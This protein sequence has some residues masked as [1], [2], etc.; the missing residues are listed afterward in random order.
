MKILIWLFTFSFFTASCISDISDPALEEALKNG[1]VSR[2][3]DDGAT[4]FSGTPWA[5]KASMLTA[6]RFSTCSV[7]D[8]KIY[9]FGGKDDS[10]NN[11][12]S[13]EVYDPIS[14]S[15]SYKSSMDTD[16]NSAA[17]V[18]V[19][20]RILIFGGQVYGSP[21]Y[22]MDVVAEYNPTSDTWVNKSQVMPAAI[23]E[24]KAEVVNNLVYLFGGT[25]ASGS[26]LSSVYE[27]DP[28]GDTYTTKSSMNYVHTRFSS[29]V[30][31]SKIYA[32]AGEID[33]SEEYDVASNS[34]QTIE[35]FFDSNGYDHAGLALNGL[36]HTFGGNNGNYTQA[37]NP[38][39]NSWNSKTGN[40]YSSARI[41][42]QCA[43]TVNGKIYLI[44]GY[45]QYS[46]SSVYE[47]DPS[48]DLL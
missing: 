1:D 5:Q 19:N 21:N 24:L 27:Y 20:G 45:T 35:D 47:Y 26:K 38:S 15:W 9:V 41:Y 22:Y 33:K 44:G 36:V 29:A 31:D 23:Y 14:N 13:V 32:I 34:W 25:N 30:V 3:V 48:K 4:D 8:G 18:T 10:D 2:D 37:Y 17:S 42:G 28:V 46:V 40:K 39:S 16:R 11:L 12:S 43:A 6:R 7:Y